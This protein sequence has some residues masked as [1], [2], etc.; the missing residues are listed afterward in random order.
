MVSHLPALLLLATAGAVGVSV[1]RVVQA[2]DLRE[3]NRRYELLC[4]RINESTS[5]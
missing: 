3:L 2:L 5:R 4:A 1:D